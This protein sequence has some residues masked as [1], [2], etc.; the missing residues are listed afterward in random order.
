MLL[1]GLLTATALAVGVVAAAAIVLDLGNAGRLVAMLGP[2]R[3]DETLAL[4]PLSLGNPSAAATLRTRSPEAP[5]DDVREAL[6]LSF[7]YVLRVG[8]GDTLGGL[9]TEAGVP[10]SEADA[11]IRALALHYNPRRLRN[12]QEIAVVFE[13]PAP[14]TVDAGLPTPG[15]FLGLSI[16][17]GYDTAVEVTRT[18]GG[19]FT[20]SVIAKTLTRAMARAAGEIDSSLYIAG[21]DAGLPHIILAELIRAFSWDVDFQRDVREGDGFEVMY[22]RAF[23]DKGREVHAGPIRFAA[24]TL[25]GK[26]HGIYLHTTAD[27]DTDYFDGGGKSARKALMRTPIDGARLSSG[28][29]K[30]MHPILGYTKMHRGVDF[31]APPGTPIYA[32]G[33]GT[34]AQAGPN[35]AYGNYLRIRHNGEYSTA[36]A[37]LRAFARGIHAGK[38]VGQGQIV[39][40][41]GTTGRST[42]PHLHYEILV[43]GQQTNPMKVRMPSGKALAGDELR[44]FATARDRIASQYAALAAAPAAPTATDARLG[45][46][47]D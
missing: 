42:G 24:L 32:A 3:A 39:G 33:S 47:R 46:A 45:G 27:G 29:G 6:P 5:R 20:A 2:D 28:F 21:R 10:A 25:S 8:R 40:Y 31:A 11:A 1:R 17:P 22:D 34:V 23:D 36:Y 35:G 19:D 4:K 44:R 37:H 13:P 7:Q 12:G 15:R 14:G 38:R 41:V 30:R 16:E 9:L 43:G 26:R 18:A